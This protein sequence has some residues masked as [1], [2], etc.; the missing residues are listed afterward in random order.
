VDVMSADTVDV[1]V[2][3]S[4]GAGLTAALTT[5]AHGLDVV[6]LERDATFGGT[7]ATSSGIVW[8]PANDAMA[9]HGIKDTEAE[10]YTYLAAC[11]GDR[12]DEAG[13]ASFIHHAADMARFLHNRHV[14]LNATGLADYFPDLPGAKARR[15]MIA[16][17]IPAADIP[18]LDSAIHLA[19]YD[20]GYCG[21]RDGSWVG[22]SA[23]IAALLVACRRAGVCCRPATRVSELKQRDDGTVAGVSGVGPEGPFTLRAMRGVVLAC[24]GFER[25]PELMEKYHGDR[26]EA[27][28][29]A[30]YN[31]GD[32]FRM[33]VAAGASVSNMD[34]VWWYCLLRVTDAVADGQPV[35]RD[36]SPA[37]NLPGSIVVDANG[38]RFANE[39]QSYH[40]LGRT[41]GER[42]KR[43]LWLICDAE[44]VDRYGAK[45]FGT[46]TPGPPWFVSAPSADQLAAAIA[47]DPAAL[48]ATVARWNEAV[49]RGADDE[50]G[51]GASAFDQNWG[52][53][54]LEGPA[55]AIGPI[56]TG[57]YW[58]TRMYAATSGTNGGPR[59]DPDGRVVDEAGHPIR[60]LY[61]AGNTTASIF[62]AA[63]PAGGATLGPMLTQA[64]RAGL[65]LA[66]EAGPS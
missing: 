13:A 12:L 30:P 14:V 33:A 65:A 2:V 11:A 42:A 25:D 3:G 26:V 18:E 7:T 44:F 24:G 56:A 5:A 58:A 48:R 46:T 66:A 55:K 59:T 4:G 17:P 39:S 28:W 23:L 51:R 27:A 41:M 49:A 9:E 21:L 20:L 53:P 40:D 54:E 34:Q 32:G 50:F 47:V 8:V 37:R 15:S 10:A 16:A 1:V 45:A 62:G 60:G 19:P 31:D 43:P 6:V 36:G 57:P 61:A 64:W 29:S 22:G 52:D 35:F 63:N 38:R